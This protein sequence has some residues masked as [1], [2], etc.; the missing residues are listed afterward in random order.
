ML[1][2]SRSAPP[3]STPPEPPSAGSSLFPDDA[4]D[5][6]P[7][8]PGHDSDV[9]DVMDGPEVLEAVK[10]SPQDSVIGVEFAELETTRRTGS[11]DGSSTPS[12]RRASVTPSTPPTVPAPE[13]AAPTPEAPSAPVA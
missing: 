9:M 2:A 8:P 11:R 4:E 6:I 3:A 5:L 10:P 7:H 12:S 1:A 13:T